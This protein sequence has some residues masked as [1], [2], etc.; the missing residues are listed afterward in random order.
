[1]IRCFKCSGNGV[2]HSNTGAGGKEHGDVIF[3]VTHG[4]G[5]GN[6][7]I[8]QPGKFS[9]TYTLIGTFFVNSR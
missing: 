4:N 2:G 1:M 9:H 6:V 5:I 7:L 8:H 3:L